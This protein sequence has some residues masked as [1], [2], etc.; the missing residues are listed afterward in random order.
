MR[1]VSPRE[2]N[3][4]TALSELYVALL[5]GSLEATPFGLANTPRSQYLPEIYY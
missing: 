1:Y 2:M 4:K 5:N 3:I